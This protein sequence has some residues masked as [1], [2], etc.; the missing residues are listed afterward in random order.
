M[1]FFLFSKTKKKTKKKRKKKNLPV[2]LEP[3]KVGR[4]V[5]LLV[6]GVGRDLLDADT[7]VFGVAD[8]EVLGERVGAGP[9]VGGLEVGRGLIFF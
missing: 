7:D 6:V 5:A 2:L 9:E 4:L 1:S 3:G 8:Q